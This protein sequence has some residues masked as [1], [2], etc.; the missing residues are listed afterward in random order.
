[1]QRKLPSKRYSSYVPPSELSTL[2]DQVSTLTESSQSD[3]SRSDCSVR[4][5]SVGDGDKV[6]RRQSLNTLHFDALQNAVSRLAR[7]DDF[8][9]EELGYG[10][11]SDVFKVCK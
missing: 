9:L 2:E 1:M 3:Q 11:F 4:A 10:F 6:L 7:I 5:G 8:Y